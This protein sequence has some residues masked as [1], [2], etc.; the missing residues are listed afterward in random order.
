VALSFRTAEAISFLEC[1][2]GGGRVK[3]E[4]E[5]KSAEHG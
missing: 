5:L 3:L 2:G 4:N 1:G